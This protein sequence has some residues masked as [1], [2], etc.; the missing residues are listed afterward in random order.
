MRGPGE[1]PLLSLARNIVRP[2]HR[3]QPLRY[4]RTVTTRHTHLFALALALSLALAQH[5]LAQ[6]APPS[7]TWST[8]ETDPV[9]AVVGLDD[10]DDNDDGVPDLAE[11]PAP[12]ASRDD[13]VVRVT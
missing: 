8:G 13:D 9:E 3:G 6:T 12:D 4:G 10:D 7:L 11:T 2:P 5:A 1:H